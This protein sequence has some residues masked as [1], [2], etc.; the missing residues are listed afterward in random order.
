MNDLKFVFRQLLKNPGFAAVAM[1]TLALGTG[2][3][4]AISINRRSRSNEALTFADFG[5]CLEK[6]EQSLLSSAATIL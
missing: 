6:E 1:L 5:R 3:N 4:T 2:A